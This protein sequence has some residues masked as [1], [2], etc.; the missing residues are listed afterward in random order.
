[1]STRYPITLRG[2]VELPDEPLRTDLY[3]TSR[4]ADCIRADMDANPGLFLCTQIEDVA[5]EVDEVET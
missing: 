5:L 1:M 4:P 2:W 3:G